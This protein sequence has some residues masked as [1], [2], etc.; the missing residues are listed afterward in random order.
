[1]QQ[2]RY[3]LDNGIGIGTYQSHCAGFDGFGPFGR[4]AHHQYRFAERGSLFLYAAAVG[5][6]QGGVLHGV[7]EG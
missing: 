1:V 7:D 3:V 6:Q 2:L 5:E 4:V